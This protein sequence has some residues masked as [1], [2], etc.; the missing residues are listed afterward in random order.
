MNLEIDMTRETKFRYDCDQVLLPNW[1][2]AMQEDHKVVK[3]RIPPR[4]HRAV[5]RTLQFGRDNLKAVPKSFCDLYDENT[6]AG[7]KNGD[8]CGT[9]LGVPVF[10]DETLAEGY[11][12]LES[13]PLNKA[14]QF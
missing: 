11:L 1:K 5:I 8:E 7:L 2:L 3:V 10:L 6:R 12:A 14:H 9:L 4:S 13:E